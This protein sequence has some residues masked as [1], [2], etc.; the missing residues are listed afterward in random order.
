MILD[1]ISDSTAPLME[2]RVYL[3]VVTIYITGGLTAS[4]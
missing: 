2:V 3:P 1:L 4:G